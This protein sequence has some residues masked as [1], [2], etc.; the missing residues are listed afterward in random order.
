M[1]N[2]KMYDNLHG[3]VA[4]DANFGLSKEEKLPWKSK[5]DMSFFKKTTL[6]NIVIMGSKTLLSLPNCK[7]LEQRFNIV[8]T[9]DKK[10]YLNN[11]EKYNNIIF[12]TLEELIILLPDITSNNMVYVIGGN[13]IYNILLPLCSNILVTKFKKDYNCDQKFD[14]NIDNYNKNIIYNDEELEIIHLIHSH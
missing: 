11:Y 8:L 13:Q 4:V 12:V 1:Y 2:I 7:P 3:I 6:N 14:Y 5:K 9:K 10:K